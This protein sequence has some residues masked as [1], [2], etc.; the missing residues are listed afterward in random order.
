M[1]FKAERFPYV[2][3]Q[4]VADDGV[5]PRLPLTL[6]LGKNFVNEM[7]LVDSGSSVNVLPYSLG[8]RLGAMW[9]QQSIPLD[10]G[11]NLASVEARGR[12]VNATISSFS[13]VRFVFA[14]AKSDKVP[15]ILGQMNFFQVFDI[16]FF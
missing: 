4:I 15:F 14:W 2:P 12:L 16:C 5:L 6:S 9:E 11:G 3:G 13:P 7:A 10:L 8:I 1:Q